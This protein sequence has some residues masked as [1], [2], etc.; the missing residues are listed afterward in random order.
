MST[1]S[2]LA[3]KS[4]VSTSFWEELY[5]RKLDV[6]GLSSDQ[7]AIQ[8]FLSPSEG[9]NTSALTVSKESYQG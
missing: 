5:R 4:F 6:Y 7:I 9:G 8:G 3:P 2:F 1:V